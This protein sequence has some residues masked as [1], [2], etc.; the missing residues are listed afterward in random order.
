MMAFLGSA[1]P[2]LLVSETASLKGLKQSSAKFNHLV[3]FGHF[4]S[5]FQITFQKG[6][7]Q[8][9]LVTFHTANQA[10][11]DPVHKYPILHTQ[12]N[13]HLAPCSKFVRSS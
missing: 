8:Q 10:L 3:D 4:Q 13:A 1:S 2:A 9:D 11:S 6:C 5:M 7:D 12:T